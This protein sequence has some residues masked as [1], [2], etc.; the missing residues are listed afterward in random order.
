L[1]L[2]RIQTVHHADVARG[3]RLALEAGGADGRIYNLADDAAL[4]AWEL[5]ALTGQ[6][7]PAGMGEVDP[8]EGIVDTRRIREELGF[9]PTYPTV[10]AAHAAEAM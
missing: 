3:L 1:V 4:T 7:A 9:R 8:W 5:C 2:L 10:Y 6:P